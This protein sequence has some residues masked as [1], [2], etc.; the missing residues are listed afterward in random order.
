MPTCHRVDRAFLFA[1]LCS[2]LQAPA[3][4]SC[5]AGAAQVMVIPSV[6]KLLR[7]NPNYSYAK[8]ANIVAAFHPDLVGVEIRPEDLLRPDDYLQRNYP[9]EMV[10]LLHRTPNHVFGF[11]WLGDELA[12]RP[13]P[14]DWWTKQSRIKQLE[15]AW[16]ASPTPSTPQ[17]KQLTQELETLSNR[18][19]ALENTASPENLATGPYDAITA[20]YYRT[21]AALTQNTP[22]A[23]VTTWYAERDRHLADNVVAQI[24]LHP[25]CRIAIV[26]GADHHGPILAAIATLRIKAVT[27][28]LP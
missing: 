28:T 2:A 13:V 18:R 22:Y 17:M 21:A 25:G 12:G 19:D 4:A 23:P 24:R 6:H 26:T 1:M 9:R 8:L 11:D 20:A 15:R 5:G 14:D 16:A 7:S 10:E 27:V 3:A